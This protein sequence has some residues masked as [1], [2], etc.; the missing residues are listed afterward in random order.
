MAIN[1]IFGAAGKALLLHEQRSAVLASNLVNS[2]TPNYKARDL[3]FKSIM[4]QQNQPATVQK[5]HSKHIGGANQIGPNQVIY[6]N[7]TQ[8]SMDGNTVDPDIERA[9]F[10]ENS[11]RYT[12]SLTFVRQTTQHYMKA[13]RGE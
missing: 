8:P 9:Q 12:A 6:R 5:T 11:L 2:S 1:N 3:D 13:I 4:Q 7:A 10:A